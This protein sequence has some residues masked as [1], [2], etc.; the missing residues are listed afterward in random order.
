DARDRRRARHHAGMDALLDAVLGRAREPQKFDAE[1]KLGR[2][3]DVER[4]YVADTLD[5]DAGDIHLG[6]ERD[7][8]QDCELVGSVHAIDVEAR[9]GLRVAEL[10]RFAQ[11]LSELAAVLAHGPEDEIRGA[12]EDAVD[13]RDLVGGQPLA[14]SLH[15]G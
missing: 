7:R 9:I 1:T 8:G 10:L 13:A 2:V 4:G 6:P 5:V 3:L 11:Y 15:D 14:Q 12:V